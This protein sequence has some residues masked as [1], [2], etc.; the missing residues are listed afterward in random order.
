[1]NDRGSPEPRIDKPTLV[2]PFETT[3]VPGVVMAHWGPEVRVGF[4][5][6]ALTMN[7]GPFTNVDQPLHFRYDAMQGT[8]P[9]V[10]ITEPNTGI[11][12]PIPLPNFTTVPLALRPSQAL[13]TTL[14]FMPGTKRLGDG[15]L[16]EF[17]AK[18]KLLREHATAVHGGMGGFQGLN[19]SAL[20]PDG[21]GLVYTS[22]SG[23]KV[24]H[25]DLVA[26]RQL[27]IVVDAAENQGKFFFD[28][29]FDADGRLLV[30][31]G[32][33][34]DAFDLSGRLLRS[35]PLPRFGWASMSTPV[36]GHVYA[37]N[38]FTGDVA[39]L[40]LAS[41]EVGPVVNTGVLKSASGIAEFT[42]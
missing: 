14:P 13:R 10:T 28:L 2:Y 1:M 42:A 40:D 27:P 32:T 8:A 41:G 5:Q 4:P 20:T 29:A 15:H 31:A 22:E 7:M 21:R 36:A 23:P 17:S 11:R 26:A 6:P 16:F 18:G 9:A 12:I 24:F 33:R 37:S 34:I 19:S 3:P 30:V 25:W 35:Y 38:F 39:R